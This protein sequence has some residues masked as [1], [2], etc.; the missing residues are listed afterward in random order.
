MEAYKDVMINL[1]I[2]KELLLAE[3]YRNY[4]RSFPEHRIFW[5]E[6]EADELEHAGWVRFLQQQASKSQLVFDEG[7]TRTYTLKTFIEHLQ[8][9]LD[10]ARRPG[11]SCERALATTLD[12]ERSLLERNVYSLFSSKAV[13][14]R[15]LLQLLQQGVRDHLAK[16][17]TYVQK[18]RNHGKR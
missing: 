2:E 5:S 4:A 16:V 10:D 1:C 15:Q 18:H 8:K 14:D 6:L 13:K 3:I 12:L 17:E 7:K 9:T 11:I